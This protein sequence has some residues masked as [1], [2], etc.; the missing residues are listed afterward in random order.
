MNE[1]KWFSTKLRFAIMIES[2]GA[3]TLNDCVFM[4]KAVDFDVAFDRAIS[5]GYASE[6]EYRNSQGQLVQWKFKEIISLDIIQSEDLDGREVYSEPI[7][8]ANEN[9]IPFE[10]EFSPKTSKPLQTI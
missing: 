6:K 9:M 7:H 3:D 1:K 10:T 2:A 5:I 4:L 8:L